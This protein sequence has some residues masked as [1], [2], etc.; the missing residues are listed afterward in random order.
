MVFVHTDLGGNG[1]CGSLTVSGEH[2]GFLNPQAAQSIDD[3]FSLCT[4]GIGNTN[5]SGQLSANG[6]V[7]MGV[8]LWKRVKARLVAIRNGT[9]L[10]FKDK[11]ALPITTRSFPTVLAIP[12]ATKYS[13]WECISSWK[14]R[15]LGQP[16]PQRWP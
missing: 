8:L 3:R 9:R 14:G 7:Q 10:V 6:K 15:D 1:C 12:W 2:N 16:V 11:C 13:T 5:D 4:K